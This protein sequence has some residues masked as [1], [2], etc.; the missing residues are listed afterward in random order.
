MT[1]EDEYLFSAMTLPVVIGPIIEKVKL[2][3]DSN[4]FSYQNSGNKCL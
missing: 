1:M 3:S 4:T 2:T